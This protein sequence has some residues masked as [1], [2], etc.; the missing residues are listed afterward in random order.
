M[1]TPDAIRNRQPHQ[2]PRSKGELFGDVGYQLSRKFF[3]LSSLFFVFTIQP[4]PI[5][6]GIN[7]EAPIQDTK[8]HQS[9]P[10][11]VGMYYR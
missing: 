8:Q 11:G 7:G 2:N 9:R 10:M 1:S 3:L 5:F 6:V 4:Y